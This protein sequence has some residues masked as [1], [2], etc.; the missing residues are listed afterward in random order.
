MLTVIYYLGSIILANFLVMHFGLVHHF[1]LVFPAGAY[2]IGITFTARDLVQR[3]YGKWKCWIW[4]G[5]A[6]IISAPSMGSNSPRNSSEAGECL[7]MTI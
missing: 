4:M 6:S 3:K 1:G 7:L 5:C 2:A